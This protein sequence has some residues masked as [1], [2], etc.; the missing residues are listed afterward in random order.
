MVIVD[1]DYAGLQ[2]TVSIVCLWVIVDLDYAVYSR[3]WKCLGVCCWFVL[4]AQAEYMCEQLFI[5]IR[6]TG[7]MCVH[8]FCLWEAQ[9]EYVN[10]FCLILLDAQPEL[11]MYYSKQLL[12]KFLLEAQGEY[13]SKLQTLECFSGCKTFWRRSK[14]RIA[15]FLKTQTQ[16]QGSSCCQ[17]W[18]GTAQTWIPCIWW[19]SFTNMAS[20]PCAVWVL[21]ICLSWGTSWQRGRYCHSLVMFVDLILW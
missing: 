4:E 14:R 9:P 17:T 6:S 8:S 18:S 1:L 3:Y 15:S 16:R 21:T 11:Y 13:I 7:R 12:L 20:S 19:P 5:F 10:S 2:L